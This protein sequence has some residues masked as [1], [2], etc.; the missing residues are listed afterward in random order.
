MTPH[1]HTSHTQEW[2]DYDDTAN[3]EVSITDFE[4]KITKI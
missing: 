4:C 3:Q 1:T 2:Y